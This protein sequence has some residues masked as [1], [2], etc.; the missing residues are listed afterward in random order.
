[1]G[2]VSVAQAVNAHEQRQ[3]KQRKSQIRAD[4]QSQFEAKQSNSV[5][6][7]AKTILISQLRVE[8]EPEQLS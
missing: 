1:M 4:W 2:S 3:N 8:F 5:R 7:W 6:S